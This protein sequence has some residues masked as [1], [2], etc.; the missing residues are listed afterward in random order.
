MPNSNNLLISCEASAAGEPFPEHLL[1][2]H[3]ERLIIK[4]NGPGEYHNVFPCAQATMA[5]LAHIEGYDSLT[6]GDAGKPDRYHNRFA[7]WGWLYQPRVLLDGFVRIIK[8]SG[9]KP[10]L[11]APQALIIRRLRPRLSIGAE[12]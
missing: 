2:L 8:R 10:Y 4:L 12:V 3:L 7:V 5:K 1:V 6:F 9:W 11:N